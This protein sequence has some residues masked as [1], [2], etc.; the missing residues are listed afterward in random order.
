[1]ILAGQSGPERP[2]RA[3]SRRLPLY[4]SSANGAI[5]PALDALARPVDRATRPSYAVWEVTL[6]C[7]LSCRHCSSRAGRARADE[8]STAEALDLVAQLAE[9]GVDEVVLIGGEVYLRD[10]WLDLVRA[11]RSHGMR[12]IL[13]TG[14]RAFSYKRAAAA[15]DAGLQSASVS[16]D[17]LR[18]T[19]EALRGARGG[20]RLALD[21]LANIRRAGIRATANTQI[22]RSNVREV[23]GLFEQLVAA[24]ISAWQPQLTVPMGRAAD[25]PEL[26]LQPFQMLEVMPMLARLKALADATGVV[27]WPGNNIGYFGPY[28]A[29]FRESLPDCHR[30]SCGAGRTVLGIESNG[31]VKPCPSLA[32]EAYVGGNV[33]EHRLRDIWERAPRLRFTRRRSVADLW[34]HCAECY[35]AEQCAGGCSWTA[36]SLLGRIGN[37][38]YCHHRSLTLL[39]HG[40]RERVER[41]MAPP[42][43][44]FDRG[45]FALVEEPWPDEEL[46]RARA[47]ARGDEYWL[48]SSSGLAGSA[49]PKK[50]VP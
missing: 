5:H 27:F 50:E 17:G 39:R 13:V 9:L 29:D 6:R 40:R 44:P 32:S 10:D 21:A 42:G 38:P 48:S 14:G 36:H 22:G 24:G 3:A 1:M 23:P 28:E 25:H 7:D 33:R 12:C 47:V 15:R 8:L 4:P 49:S 18:A 41:T 20:F 26:V 11:V 19:H 37:N 34:G 2:E 30:G 16:I 46:A 45:R 31:N 35:Y 43:Q